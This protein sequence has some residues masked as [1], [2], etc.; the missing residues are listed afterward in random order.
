MKLKNCAKDSNQNVSSCKLHYMLHAATS[1]FVVKEKSWLRHQ[2]QHFHEV[3]E[4]NNALKLVG[5]L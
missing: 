4:D 5:T 1:V 3:V 2:E